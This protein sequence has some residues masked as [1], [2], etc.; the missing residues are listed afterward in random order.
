MNSARKKHILEKLDEHSF[1]KVSDLQRELGVTLMTVRRDLNQ[2]EQE[3][4]LVRVHGGA[5]KVEKDLPAITTPN[6]WTL[7][8][9]DRRRLNAD[10]K[11]RIAQKAASLI[12]D[13]DIVF[14]SASTTNERIAQYMKARNV[15]IVT[16]CLYIFFLF[17]KMEGVE[18]MLIGG[19]Y[20]DFLESFLGTMTYEGLSKVSFTKAFVG[21]NAITDNNLYASNEE[22]GLL[23]K[24]ALDNAGER[25]VVCDS[26]KFNTNAF[27]N[28]YDCRDLTAIIT[29]RFE[30]DKI[31][32]YREITNII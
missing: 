26:T 12:Q 10:K 32:E 11:E 29:D 5:Q 16:N 27:F 3:G 1:V 9:K 18:A 19:R 24:L 4:Y 14:I 13:N 6:V 28:F 31:L 22:E 21:T 20:D 17:Y 25:Y 23:H 30:I 15:K 2:L 8:H 7:K